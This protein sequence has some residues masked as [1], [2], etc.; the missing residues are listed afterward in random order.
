MY[1]DQFKSEP[2]I[3]YFMQ[4][5]F[6]NVSALYKFFIEN[7]AFQNSDVW[8]NVYSSEDKPYYDKLTIALLGVDW[9]FGSKVFQ[10]CKDTMLEGDEIGEQSA[11]PVPSIFLT[12][13]KILFNNLLT[14]KVT[15]FRIKY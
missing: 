9:Y 11:S 7:E 10:K 12:G 5:S 1:E 6:K 8:K 4:I 3:D 2:V 15:I 14:I 13:T